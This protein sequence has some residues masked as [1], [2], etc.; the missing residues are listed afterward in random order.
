MPGRE[1]GQGPAREGSG[2][3]V[4]PGR[5]RVTRAGAEAVDRDSLPG[6]ALA[7]VSREQERG[8]EKVDLF[9][10]ALQPEV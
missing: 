10:E 1:P 2:P 5:D 8:A 4:V 7:Q 6:P 3:P 9:A